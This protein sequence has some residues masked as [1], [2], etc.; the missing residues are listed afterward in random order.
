MILSFPGL[1]PSTNLVLIPTYD[2]HFYDH[3]LIS[4]ITKLLPFMTSFSHFTLPTA[5]RQPPIVPVFSFSSQV[6]QH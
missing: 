4:V 5:I 6:V 1:F 3:I 2:T